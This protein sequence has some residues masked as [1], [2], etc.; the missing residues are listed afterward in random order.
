MYICRS[1]NFSFKI[2]FYSFMYIFICMYIICTALEMSLCNLYKILYHHTQIISYLSVKH[3]ESKLLRMKKGLCHQMII[4]YRLCLCYSVLSLCSLVIYTTQPHSTVSPN[5][6][7]PF[8]CCFF[9][10]TVVSSENGGCFSMRQY[11]LV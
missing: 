4:F 8:L 9:A 3:F 10:R 6:F 1:E 5:D 11:N 7:Y 2:A